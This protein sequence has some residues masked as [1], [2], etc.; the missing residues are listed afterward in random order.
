MVDL[1]LNN[2][3]CIPSQINYEILKKTT[4]S[5]EF[6]RGEHLDKLLLYTQQNFKHKY[7]S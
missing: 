1:D 2:H 3:D 6:Q 5:K 4:N 7:L